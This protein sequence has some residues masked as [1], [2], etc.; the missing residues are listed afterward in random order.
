MT[1][2]TPTIRV[3]DNSTSKR[4]PSRTDRRTRN[5]EGVGPRMNAHLLNA[6]R[7]LEQILSELHPEYDW[8]VGVRPEHLA[9]DEREAASTVGFGETGAVSDDPDPV[10]KGNTLPPTGGLDDDALDKAA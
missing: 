6:A 10:V 9:D 7:T 1:Y 5:T 4:E 8:T 3:V 2:T